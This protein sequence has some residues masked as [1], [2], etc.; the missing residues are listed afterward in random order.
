MGW[1]RTAFIGLAAATSI[2]GAAHAGQLELIYWG[3]GSL[4]WFQLDGTSY[5]V[6]DDSVDIKNV[7]AGWHTM[8]YGAN[9][10][11]YSVSVNLSSDN[12][13]GAD[14]WCMDLDRGSF[15]LLD[16][17]SCEEMWD[18]YYWF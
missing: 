4:E 6:V 17:Y 11:T 18:Y 13:A 8:T 9:G 2:A 5:S 12:A 7:Y 14:R 1:F 15:D 3:E 16:G 10:S